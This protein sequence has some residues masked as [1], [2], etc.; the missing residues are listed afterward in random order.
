[1][2][3]NELENDDS[4][5]EFKQLSPEEQR[6][7][8]LTKFN[9]S[10][11]REMPKDQDKYLK[12][13]YNFIYGKEAEKMLSKSISKRQNISEKKKTNVKFNDAIEFSRN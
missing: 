9:T 4:V 11:N 1:M 12:N 3:T 5:L 10:I 6:L 7:Y 13:G 2:S 8:L